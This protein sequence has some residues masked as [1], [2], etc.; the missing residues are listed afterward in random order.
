MVENIRQELVNFQQTQG[1]QGTSIMISNEN[2]LATLVAEKLYVKIKEDLITSGTGI[3]NEVLVSLV[4]FLL[5][6]AC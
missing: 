1:S 6:S 2:D 4:T 3:I 5:I